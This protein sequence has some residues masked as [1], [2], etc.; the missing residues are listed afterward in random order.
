MISN[1]GKHIRVGTVLYKIIVDNIEYKTYKVQSDRC[2][3]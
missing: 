2:A 1:L 3:I